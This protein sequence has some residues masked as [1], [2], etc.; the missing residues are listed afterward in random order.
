M[1]TVKKRG[2]PAAIDTVPMPER[3]VKGIVQ[4]VGDKCILEVNGLK[5]E[6]PVGPVVPE[7]E[8][9]RFVGKE[10]TA[11]F[12]ETRPKD[13]VAIG[14]WPTPEK[15]KFHCLLCYIP[16]PDIIRRIDTRVQKVLIR[17]MVNAKIISRTLGR[18]L[19]AR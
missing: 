9:K 5:I 1:P 11:F 12:S 4:K 2:G 6:I 8:V 18:Y 15:L 10:V 19:Q 16:A 14:T 13:V 7:A 17:E 3:R